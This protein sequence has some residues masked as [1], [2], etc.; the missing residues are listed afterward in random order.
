MALI[1]EYRLIVDQEKA[2]FASL[3]TAQVASTL[4][5]IKIG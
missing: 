5:P 4:N 2:S 1:P 3:S